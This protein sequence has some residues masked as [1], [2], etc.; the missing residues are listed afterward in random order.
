MEVPD[1]TP[2]TPELRKA[3]GAFFTPAP[4][5][6][7]LADWAL[8]ND[9]TAVVLDPTCGESVFLEAAGRHLAAL[10]VGQE[11]IREQ[12]LGV[13]L[14][15]GSVIESRRLLR[16][17]GL[18]GTFYTGDFFAELLPTR[19]GARLPLVDAVI[20]NPPFVRFQ[21]HTGAERKRA[22]LAALEQG[23][24]LNGLASSWAAMVVHACGFLQPEGRLAMVLPTELLHTGYAEPVR[25]W[26]KR[27]FKAV[28]LIMFEELVFSDATEKVVLVLARGQGGTK[29][30]S[31]APVQTADDLR[32]LRFA[33]PTHVNVAPP[34][35]GKWT[36]LLLATEHRQVFDRVTEEHFT[37]LGTYGHPQ[38]GTVTGANE[39][40][41][42]SELTRVAYDIDPRH[43]VPMSPPGTKHF[44]GLSY[45]RKDWERLRDAGER[46]WM[47]L[48]QDDVLGGIDGPDDEGLRRYLAEGEARDVHLAYKCRVRS[49]W[50]RPPVVDPPDLFFTYMSHRFPRIVTNAVGA[51]FPNSMHGI[52]LGEDAP[53]EAKVA[54]PLL[55]M[56]AAT[57]LSAEIEGRSYGGGI[58][59]MEPTE[60]RRLSVP[61][62]EALVEAWLRLKKDR[63]KLERRLQQGLWADVAK[64]VDEALLI[65]AC[66]VP[67]ADVAD[68][69]AAATEL[70]R[71]RMGGEV[72]PVA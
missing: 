24:R 58:L 30:F 70:R 20:G 50:Y 15:E 23:V 25:S 53:A 71:A 12:V 19:I 34:D 63:A 37:A 62:P 48:P 38:L 55:V 26:L 27:R 11:Q 33:G 10:G 46:V 8:E 4:I 44:K 65:G 59:K 13:D 57:M 40:F 22:Q 60:A 72:I 66:G 17:Q 18:D 69:H 29:A 54:L 52:R 64:R 41:C 56:N 67:A 36:D 43:L 68:L 42:I 7:Y 16:E 14:H 3:R 2:D 35:K 39:F 6:D 49:T 45:T 47:L 61:A 31:L 28:H 51:T 32:R 21:E 9:P 5:A 1:L